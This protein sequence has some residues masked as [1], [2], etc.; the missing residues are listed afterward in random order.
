MDKKK[1]TPPYKMVSEGLNTWGVVDSDGKKVLTDESYTVASNLEFNLNNPD[2]YEP[3]ET[4]EIAGNI[5][6][7][8]KEAPIIAGVIE[9]KDMVKER[10][11]SNLRS[12]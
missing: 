12:S 6:N 1:Y 9:R 5:R 10:V 4:Y 8:I 7:A 2:H 11:L 3:T